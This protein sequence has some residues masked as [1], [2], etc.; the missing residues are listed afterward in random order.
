MDDRRRSRHRGASAG[1][2]CL[3][4]GRGGLMRRQ[5]DRQRGHRARE[6]HAGHG[7]GIAGHVRL[8]QHHVRRV[9]QEDGRHVGDQQPLRLLVERQPLGRVE[10]GVGPR[11]QRVERGVAVAD[12][13]GVDQSRR[14]SSSRSASCG[15]RGTS[16]NQYRPSCQLRPGRRRRRRQSVRFRRRETGTSVSS[17]PEHLAVLGGQP[18]GSGAGPPGRPRRSTRRSPAGSPARRRRTSA[19]AC[20]AFVG[21]EGVGVGLDVAGHPRRDPGQGRRAVAVVRSPGSTP[22]GRRRRRTPRGP[23]C[24]GTA[25]WSG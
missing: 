7:D 12:P 16:W 8:D 20:R 14:R 5:V 17:T 21:V 24:P 4:F 19:S 6:S 25:P 22:R 9:G 11:D 23:S 13:F 18:L 15:D 10:L 1:V 2:V 3:R